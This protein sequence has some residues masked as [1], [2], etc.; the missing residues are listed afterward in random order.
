MDK[1]K[2]ITVITPHQLST[3]AKM[4][5]R[6]GR[7][8]FVKLIPN[9]GYTSSSKQLDQ[10]IDLEIYIHIEKVNGK[11]YLTIQ[12]GKHRGTGII[13]DA[14]KY[15]VLPFFDVGGLRDDINGPDSTLRK[16][17]GGPIGSGDEVP[18]FSFENQT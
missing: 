17:G 3:E 12:R 8:D 11:S 1:K 5:I 4:L 16:P 2:K 14:Q 18:F 7:Q 13:P 9:L 10:E 6:D 15:M